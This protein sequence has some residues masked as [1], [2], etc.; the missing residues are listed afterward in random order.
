MVN[1]G[2][3]L[4]WSGGA[5]C[6]KQLHTE[7]MHSCL[8]FQLLLKKNFLQFG[9]VRFFWVSS[10]VVNILALEENFRW[11]IHH[12]SHY[13]KEF[14]EVCNSVLMY[15]DSNLLFWGLCEYGYSPSISS[16]FVV[17][18]VLFFLPNYFCLYG[19]QIFALFEMDLTRAFY[20]GIRFSILLFS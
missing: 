7:E 18:F 14:N 15:E 2:V 11:C 19:L 17:F 5:M 3:I 9:L 20:K 10:C 13:F 4:F 6:W 12:A 1:S 16:I 8:Q